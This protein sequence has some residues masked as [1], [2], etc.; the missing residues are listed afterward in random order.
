[1]LVVLLTSTACTVGR[2]MAFTARTNSFCSD[3]VTGIAKL[4]EPTSPI[5]QMQYAMDRYTIV[6][7]AVSELTDSR[8]P[9]GTS[10][11]QLRERWLRPAR[12]ALDRGR[13]A[14]QDLRDAVHAH[15][16]G[17]ATTEFAAARSV[18]IEGVDTALL[19]AKGLGRCATLF[20]A[21]KSD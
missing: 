6:E 3:A 15:D 17:A 21:A 4:A 13:T 14:L 11:Q 9:G 16:V 8:L 10:G 12:A 2:P 18:G 1:M 20:S 5:E 7:K 19:S